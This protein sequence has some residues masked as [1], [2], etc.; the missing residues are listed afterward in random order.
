M[1]VLFISVLEWPFY[2]VNRDCSP[3]IPNP[4]IPA[5]FLN[6]ESRD[7][8]NPESRDCRRP[9]PGISGLKTYLLN[10]LLNNNFRHRKNL[11]ASSNNNNK[12]KK[13]KK[14]MTSVAVR[15]PSPYCITLR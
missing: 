14:K 1:S 10:C 2:I 3:G 15:N 13:K 9:N 11:F 5:A 6:P 8:L 12:K 4:G 7:F